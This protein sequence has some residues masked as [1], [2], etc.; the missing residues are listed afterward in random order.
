ML[1]MFGLGVGDLVWMAMLTSS[2]FSLCFHR[3]CS[4]V[5]KG[6]NLSMGM[7]AVQSVNICHELPPFVLYSTLA[8]RKKPA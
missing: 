3:C 4:F 6:P 2:A 5:A 1:V 7:K 8:G